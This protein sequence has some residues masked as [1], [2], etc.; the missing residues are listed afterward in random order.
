MSLDH[1]RSALEQELALLRLNAFAVD[2]TP[3]PDENELSSRLAEADLG[4]LMQQRAARRI[5]E[6]EKALYR[7]EVQTFGCCESCGEDIAMRRL[8][9]NPAARLCLECQEELEGRPRRRIAG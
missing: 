6:I 3:C 9:A 1:L 4:V 8:A 2:T 5:R 7:M